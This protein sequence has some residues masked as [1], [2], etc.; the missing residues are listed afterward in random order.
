MMPDLRRER[1]SP[2]LLRKPHTRF[3]ALI[4]DGSLRWP[5]S[6]VVVLQPLRE[7]QIQEPTSRIPNLTSNWEMVQ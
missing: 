1:R 3:A 2:S 7:H 6:E 4:G 5:R